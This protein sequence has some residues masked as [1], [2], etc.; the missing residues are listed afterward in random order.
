MF[1]ESGP[2]TDTHEKDFENKLIVVSQ[3]FQHELNLAKN[4]K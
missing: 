4:E 3:L 1:K 2:S